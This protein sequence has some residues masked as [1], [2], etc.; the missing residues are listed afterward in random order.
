MKKLFSYF[1]TDWQI[2]HCLIPHLIVYSVGKLFH[3][4]YFFAFFS[5]LC[6]YFCFRYSHL[7]LLALSMAFLI[8]FFSCAF[9]H[10]TNIKPLCFFFPSFPTI[11]VFALIWNWLS[12]SRSCMN[13]LML[14]SKLIYK[15]SVLGVLKFS[16]ILIISQLSL[17]AI[18]RSIS[19]SSSACWNHVFT[20]AL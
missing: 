11:A 19:V 3:W 7:F 8:L 16:Y 12:L 5:Q 18:L 2:K 17:F 4:W 20:M 1:K 14:T 15:L 9:L 10:V 13:K 6:I